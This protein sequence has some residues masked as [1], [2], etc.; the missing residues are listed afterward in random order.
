MT[1]QRTRRAALAKR[2]QAKAK[3][4]SERLAVDDRLMITVMDRLAL[5]SIADAPQG[6]AVEKVPADVLQRLVDAGRVAVFRGVVVNRGPVMRDARLSDL[7]V[8]E[9]VDPDD[10]SV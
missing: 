10:P 4:T 6:M 7:L 8:Y 3:R 2:Q 1:G 5:E 9:D